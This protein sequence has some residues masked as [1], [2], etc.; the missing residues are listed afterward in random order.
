M[1]YRDRQVV[2]TGGTGALGTAVVS[3]LLA[4]GAVCHVPYIDEQKIQLSPHSSLGCRYRPSQSGYK[5]EGLF[6]VRLRRR[7]EGQRCA[8]GV[9]HLTP[10]QR[11]HAKLLRPQHLG[12]Q[13]RPR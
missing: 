8:Q 11:E 6:R 1:S 12:E 7:Y 9:V 4:A 2:V 13:Q 10:E 3:A 5:K